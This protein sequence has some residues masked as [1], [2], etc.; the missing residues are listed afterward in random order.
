MSAFTVIAIGSSAGGLEPLQNILS[1]L[2][3]PFNAAIVL[4][5]HIPKGNNSNL[6]LIL[7]R[8]TDIPVIKVVEDTKVE[9]GKIY[10]L[11]IGK[12]MTVINGTLTLRDRSEEE[13]INRG[14]D[15]LFISLAKDIGHYAIGVILSGAGLDGLQG[16]MAIEDKQ[17]LIIVQDPDTAQFGLMPGSLVAN[18]HPDY[19]LSPKDI[20][21]KLL[22][23]TALMNE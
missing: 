8:V 16:A 6:A 4:I 12:I 7:Q 13:N 21:T 5:H 1:Q 19:V 14:I 3:H 23:K 11:G 9:K 17:G 18:D 10:A 2:A 15:E 22:E 20:A